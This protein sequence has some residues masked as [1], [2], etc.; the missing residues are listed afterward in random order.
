MTNKILILLILVGIISISTE[1]PVA[2]IFVG[3]GKQFKTIQQAIDQAPEESAIVIEPGV[4]NE[5]IK[6][7]KPVSISGLESDTS[8]ILLISKPQSPAIYIKSDNV[9]ISNIRIKNSNQSAIGMGV[10]LDGVKNCVIRN[11]WI[12]YLGPFLEPVLIINGA[13]MNKIDSNVILGSAHTSGITINSSKQNTIN[14]NFMDYGCELLKFIGCDT[15]DNALSDNTLKRINMFGRLKS[16]STANSLSLKIR[17]HDL[18]GKEIIKSINPSGWDDQG[19][20]LYKQ[21]RDFCSHISNT[22]VTR[23]WEI[24]YGGSKHPTYAIVKDSISLNTLWS[25]LRIAPVKPTIDFSKSWLILIQPGKTVTQYNYKV[26]IL[27]ENKSI[28]FDVQEYQTKKAKDLL[29]SQEAI[30][31]YEIPITQKNIKVNIQRCKGSE[32]PYPK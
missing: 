15:I 22:I 9:I 27:D 1:D 29:L 12:G 24:D 21:I 25:K 32:G 10:M 14:S 30:I 13:S 6:I 28:Q 2:D 19:K 5:N 16:D 17:M 23:Y 11:N 31:A 7:L 8:C 18:S 4:Y 20:L 26:D 3:K